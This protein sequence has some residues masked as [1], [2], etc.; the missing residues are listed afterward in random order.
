MIEKT[1]KIT[2]KHG[3]HLRPSMVIIDEASR[4]KSDITITRNGISA[5]AKSILELTMLAIT[6][7]SKIK[8]TAEGE[9]EQKAMKAMVKL[10]VGNFENMF[11]VER[12]G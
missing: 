11:N 9:D 1:I 3:I 4:Y 7:N 5:N 10:F 12:E 8:I 6:K 2:N